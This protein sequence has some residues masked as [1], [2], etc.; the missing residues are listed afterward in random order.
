MA[1]SAEALRRKRIRVA[2][3]QLVTAKTTSQTS[4]GVWMHDTYAAPAMIQRHAPAVSGATI[5]QAAAFC[6]SKPM[7]V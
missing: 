5:C 3:C 4:A 7:M 1:W 6:T 2:K